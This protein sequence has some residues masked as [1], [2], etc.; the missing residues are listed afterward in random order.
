M[1]EV[2]SARCR[3]RRMPREIYRGA[4]DG[5][6]RETRKVRSSVGPCGLYYF[7]A[8]AVLATAPATRGAKNAG[9]RH[10]RPSA[11]I[12]PPL[13]CQPRSAAHLTVPIF[14]IIGAMKAQ[15]NSTILWPLA[16]TDGNAF[17]QHGKTYHAMQQ[18]TTT[19]RRT[20][21]FR[22]TRRGATSSA[23]ISSTG[24]A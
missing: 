11:I 2:S 7:V 5:G 12:M 23:T 16:A 17:F 22:T 9:R 15:Y 4:Q 1:R 8:C 10:N 19:R 20:R 6:A 18:T 3:G 21:R 13:E 14:H 24:A